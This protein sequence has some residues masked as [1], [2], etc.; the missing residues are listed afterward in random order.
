MYN[1]EEIAS[2]S[3]KKSLYNIYVGLESRVE[4][5][6]DKIL[7]W[8]FG[9]VVSLVIGHFF[10][11]WFTNKI[12]KKAGCHNEVFDKY[13][14]KYACQPSEEEFKPKPLS[15]GLQG[16]I[17]RLFFT[18]MFGFGVQ[19]APIAMMA[20]LG[21]KMLTNLNRKDLPEH[22]I[23]R[24]RALTGFLGATVSLFFALIGGLLCTLTISFPFK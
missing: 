1:S 11:K 19:G 15:P 22:E 16:Y 2:W 20:W 12:R 24:S 9:L 14:K 23:V 17:E 10:T 6:T 18:I 4:N 7:P 8:I 5:M 21:V 13:L 3:K